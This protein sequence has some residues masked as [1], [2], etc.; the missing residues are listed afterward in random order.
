MGH[1]TLDAQHQQLLARCEALVD[2][3]EPAQAG[4]NTRLQALMALADEHF[5]T[6]EAVLDQCAYPDLD[7]LRAERQEFA[8]L[9]ADLVTPERTEAFSRALVG[10]PHRGHCRDHALVSG[11]PKP[12]IRLARGLS[13]DIFKK[14]WPHPS[15]EWS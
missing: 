13:R 12:L 15:A 6:E 11:A 2:P 7:E 14:K 10:G 8:D 4:F 9:M 3:E 1:D 5:D